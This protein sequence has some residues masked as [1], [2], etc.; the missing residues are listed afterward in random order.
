MM[1]LV[2]SGDEL[3]EEI[4]FD[5]ISTILVVVKSLVNFIVINL[6]V[7]ARCSEVKLKD[8]SRE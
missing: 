3:I 6:I 8:L 1:I 5:H 2:P 7:L 4:G